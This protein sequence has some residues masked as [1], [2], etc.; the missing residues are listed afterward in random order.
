MI[1]P[2]HLWPSLIFKAH[3]P[4]D[5]SEVVKLC[6]TKLD[7]TSLHGLEKDGGKTTFNT[8]NNLIFDSTCDQMKQWLTVVANE[9]WQRWNFANDMPRFIH[10]SWVNLHPPGAYTNEH[11]HGQCHQTIVIY[12]KQPENGGN[13]MFRDP[14]QYTFSGY[15]KIDRNEWKTVEVNQNDVLFFPGFLHHMTEKNHSHEDRL[16]MTLTISVDIFKNERL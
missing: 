1:E 8:A 6:R 5:L 10:R 14:L 12:L 16:V 9:V 3:C 11:D 2:V 13:I 4:L 15:P 7:G